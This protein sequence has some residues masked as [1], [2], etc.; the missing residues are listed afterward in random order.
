M[1][2]LSEA[3]EKRASIMLSSASVLASKRKVP[4][5]ACKCSFGVSCV[6]CSEKLLRLVEFSSGA[7]KYS[8]Y[9]DRSDCFRFSLLMP[10]KTLS[11]LRSG[12]SKMDILH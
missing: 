7:G 2:V 1:F 6:P 10:A 3:V 5:S 12:K 11:S 8:T 9:P 4:A